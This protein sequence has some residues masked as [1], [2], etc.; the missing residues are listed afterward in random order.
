[1]TEEAAAEKYDMVD[2]YTHVFRPMH[3]RICARSTRC[4]ETGGGIPGASS[5]DI[6]W[7]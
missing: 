5:G 3:A 6:S 4:A 2:V 7:A 1:M